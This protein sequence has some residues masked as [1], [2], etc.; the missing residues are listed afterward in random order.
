MP[1]TITAAAVQM[2]ATPGPGRLDRAAG[3][4]ATVA[5]R[6]A[7]LVVLPELFATGYCYEPDNYAVAVD[8][9]ATIVK[10]MQREAQRHTVYLAGSLLTRDGDDIYHALLL[11]APDG[12]L[13][14]GDKQYPFLWERA[15]ARD[16]H[17]FTVAQT[18]IG[19]IGLITYWDAAHPDVWQRYAG[20]VD[21]MAVVGS[22]PR[23]HTGDFI[24]PDGSTLNRRDLGPALES[25][26]TE[27]G[28][29][30][31]ESMAAFAAWLG[32]PL[33][34]SSGAGRMTSAMP[35]PHLSL[36]A[37]LLFR[38]DL[39]RHIFNADDARVAADFVQQTS[40]IDGSGTVVAHADGT[41]DDCALADLALADTRPNPTAPPPRSPLP[42]PLQ[43]FMDGVVPAVMIPVYRRELRRRYG[44]RM[45]PVD[46]STQ[47]W[48]AATVTAG[49]GGLIVGLLLG[50]L[51]RRR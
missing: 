15:F 20:R 34:Q 12:R 42:A 39:L 37:H 31:A 49:V 8:G 35:A 10:W 29:F 33:V 19:R 50:W 45:A 21:V 38:P 28:F 14:R 25:V 30:T 5:E 11:V 41:G 36:G 23:T 46:P 7:Q 27:R 26:G 16:G 17:T 6:G 4:V 48:R 32:V 51:G 43:F 18:D 2:E 22:A 44:D 40:I 24:L 47:V 13:W 1:K 3:L 9:A